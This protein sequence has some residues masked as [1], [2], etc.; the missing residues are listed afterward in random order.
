V[1]AKLPLTERG[2]LG[3]PLLSEPLDRAGRQPRG[4]L[5][6]QIPQRRGEV[7]GREPA[8]VQDRQHLSHLRRAPR[9]RRQDPRAKPLALPALLIDALVV[10][11]R[12]PE[13]DRPRADRH[14][15]LPRASVTDD[16]PLVVLIDLVHERA[17]VLLGLERRGDHPPR[18]LPRE[19]VQREPDLIVALPDGE[20]ANI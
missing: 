20:P 18:A 17:D 19:V 11:A 14:A 12:R 10:H 13:R 16:Q 6:Q 7:P 1:E 3:L 4:V 15:P 9:V 2:V 5:A 8:Q